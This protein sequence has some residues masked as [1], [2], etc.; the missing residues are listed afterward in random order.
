MLLVN[1]RLRGEWH[2]TIELR[3]KSNPHPHLLVLDRFH[4]DVI[5][6]L[7]CRMQA[8]PDDRAQRRK[9]PVVAPEGPDVFND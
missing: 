9:D 7:Q 1:N 5:L 6:R 4:V 8:L 2:I 3:R